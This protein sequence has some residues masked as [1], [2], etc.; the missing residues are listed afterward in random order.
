MTDSFVRSSGLIC[1]PFEDDN[2]AVAY[3][4]NNKKDVIEK[5]VKEAIKYYYNDLYEYYSSFYRLYV[6]INHQ[7][8][9]SSM[10]SFT[11]HVPKFILAQINT[12]RTL[13][14][15][16]ASSRAVSKIKFIRNLI[17]QPVLPFFT[18]NK[19]GMQGD[20]IGDISIIY[21]LLYEHFGMMFY[22]IEHTIH[23]MS[24]MHKQNANRY[25]EP[26]AMVP[27][28]ISGNWVSVNSCSGWRHFCKLRN[29][30]AQFEIQTISK[31][32]NTVYSKIEKECENFNCS[33]CYMYN[34]SIHLEDSVNYNSIEAV[35]RIS[36]LHVPIDVNT[37]DFIELFS[38]SN[39]KEKYSW[40]FGV[41][42]RISTIT[43]GDITS[44]INLSKKLLDNGH[45][46]P[47]E[48]VAL[49]KEGCYYNLR[50]WASYRYFVEGGCA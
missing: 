49:R 15:N 30:E 6:T 46:S 35:I 28:I 38:N 26:F 1:L 16:A 19:K 5:M 13:S 41:I 25:L 8:L 2:D 40:I 12:H 43:Q 27:V 39:N 22:I 14:K 20:L 9:S 7:D 45:L 33:K 44:N 42:A 10:I 47:F 48:H 23:K 50:N 31:F 18:L 4:I 3:A 37:D 11:G 21:D 17:E 29:E 34:G 32:V 36:D 24:N